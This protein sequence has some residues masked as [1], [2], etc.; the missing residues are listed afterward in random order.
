MKDLGENLADWVRQEVA[1]STF[2]MWFGFVVGSCQY[3]VDS[4]LMGF[5]CN[6]ERFSLVAKRY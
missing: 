2:L 5:S 6:S 1:L 4:L 3:L